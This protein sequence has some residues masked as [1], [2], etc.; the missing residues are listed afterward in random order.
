[1]MICDGERDVTIAAYGSR[2]DEVAG[3]PCLRGSVFSD[4]RESSRRKVAFELDLEDCQL[5]ARTVSPQ[6]RV[7]SPALQVCKQR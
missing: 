4:S 2:R 6:A 3:L 1:M 5:Q 7:S